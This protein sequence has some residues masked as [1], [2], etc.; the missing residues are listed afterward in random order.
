MSA[1]SIVR[2]PGTLQRSL[3][4]GAADDGGMPRFIEVI[5]AEWADGTLV[6]E[7]GSYTGATILEHHAMSSGSSGALWEAP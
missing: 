5:I 6:D 7:C 1:P 4:D 3:V 2:D